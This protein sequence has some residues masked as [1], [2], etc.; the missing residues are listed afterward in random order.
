MKRYK[1]KFGYESLKKKLTISNKI[2]ISQVFQG[3]RDQNTKVVNVF[4]STIL[5]KFI[6]INPLAHNGNGM[7]LR[8]DVTGCFFGNWYI[9]YFILIGY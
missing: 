9:M 3:S 2:C 8:F 5:A 1:P 6:R 7:G 4:K